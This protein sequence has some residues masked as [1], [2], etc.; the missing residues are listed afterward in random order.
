MYVCISPHRHSRQFSLAA[1]NWASSVQAGEHR[2]PVTARLSA[3]LPVQ[4][5]SLH[6][7]AYI[8]LDP[9]DV[10]P[11][12]WWV[13]VVAL[14]LLPDL[15]RER[16]IADVTC[17][18]THSTCTSGTIPNVVFV[19]IN[20]VLQGA[21]AQGNNGTIIDG[22]GAILRGWGATVRGGRA[23]FRGGGLAPGPQF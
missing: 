5:T 18:H 19:Q 11:S 17:T 8:S 1:S 20:V 16:V 4:W 21:V 7:L 3:R 6:H 22:K 2:L 12:A 14:S 13:S 10:P 15:G 9:H 23:H